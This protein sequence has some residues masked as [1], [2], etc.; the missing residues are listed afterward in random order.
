MRRSSIF[1]QVFIVLIGVGALAFLLWEPHIEG[2]NA[3]STLF[4]IYFND[5]FLAYVYLASIPFF[6]VLYQAVKFLGYFR[7]NKVFSPAAFKALRIIKY[8]GISIIGFVVIG[9]IFIILSNSDDHAGGVFMGMLITVVSVVIVST[10]IIIERILQ[11]AS[12]IKSD[13]DYSS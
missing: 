4:E 7:R 13:N 11:K 8:C 1:I 2:R 5:P 6:T 3:H 12:E 10:A 9:E